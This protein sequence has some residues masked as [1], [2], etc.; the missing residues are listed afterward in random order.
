MKIIAF[1]LITLSVFSVANA[2]KVPAQYQK[3]RRTEKVINP[4][5]TFNYFEG[6]GVN[7]GY[8]GAGFNDSGWKAVSIPHTWS[9]YGTTGE[10]NPF[11]LNV[12]ESENPYWWTGWGWY[13]K[14]FSISRD[15]AD[16]KA[17]IEFEGVQK[18][19]RVWLNG[20]Y[21]GEHKGGYGSF[22][23][24]ISQFVKFGEDNLLAV[25]VYNRQK[26]EYKI[27]PMEPGNFNVYG[28]I[29]RD[30]KLVLTDK[31]YIPMQG[32]GTH[33]GGTF[34]TTPHISEKEAVARV[35]TWVKND[36]PDKKSCTLISSILDAGGAVVQT[37]KTSV[38]I[39]PG[40][41]FKFDQTFKPIKNPR[42]WSNDN[43]YLYTVKTQVTEGKTVFDEYTSPLG[44]R[45]YKWNFGDNSLLLN[46]KK[47][48]LHGGA[49]YQ[50][51][52]WLGDAI[53][54]WIT[55][56]DLTDMAVNLN[57]N[58]IRTANYPND[59]IVYDLADKLGLVVL[60]EVPDI[61]D[62]DFSPEAQELQVR[63][64]I[65]R[66]R[67]HPGIIFWA[68]GEET[69]HPADAKY[70][71]AE[72]TSRILGAWMVKNGSLSSSVRLNEKNL[73]MN[74]LPGSSVRGWYNKDVKNL[75]TN[76][77][78]QSGT[79]ENG[80]K[81]LASDER[82]GK[83]NIANLIYAD[84]GSNLVYLNSPLTGISTD[85]TVDPYRFPKYA[86]YLWQANY[87]TS[88]MVF[89]RPHFWRSQYLGQQKDIVVSSN[90]DKVELKVNGE[91]KGIK[92]PGTGDQ[93]SVTFTGITV[94][95]GT[96]TAIGTKDG[97]TI[98]N[99]IVLAGKPAK[100]LLTC[101]H[102][103]II[104]DRASVA[105]IT[106][107]ITDSWG[108]HVYGAGN[109]IKWNV[110]GPATLAGPSIYESDIKKN[111]EKEGAWYIDMPVSNII[112]S[113][114]VKGLI[115]IS[116]SASELASGSVDLTAEEPV[117]D[118][119]V[120]YEPELKD[121]GRSQVV[122]KKLTTGRLEEIPREIKE[123]SSGINLGNTDKS[124]YKKA[125][126]AYI[127]KDNETVDT[128]TVEF[129]TLIDVLTSLLANS[130]GQ[131]VADDYNFSVTH[132][133]Y[134]RL[135]SRYINSTKLPQ[136]FKDGLRKYYS[137]E[138]ILKGT[139]KN[140]G[141]EMNWLNWIPSGGT[142]VI[143]Q[144]DKLPAT[145]KGVIYTKKNEL[146][147]IIS[148]VYPQFAGFSQEAKER[149]LIFISKA[150][151]YIHV[152]PQNGQAG[153]ETADKGKIFYTAEPGHPILIPLIKFL[154][155]K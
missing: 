108:N 74:Y 7:K 155:E 117:A 35:M 20:K 50:D 44:F 141:D 103:K 121:E 56:R 134:C 83:G 153:A 144:D 38:D 75:E 154:S 113:T 61:K 151:P 104:A 68:L 95:A 43:P 45:W 123:A 26:D 8:E 129:R 22:D 135:I 57:F 49:R 52:P 47:M 32:S 46:G 112:R 24:D 70:A 31:L 27:P 96:L 118:N 25:A 148:V 88:P 94:E 152:Q 37:V 54:K 72:D 120:I 13:R 3:S 85:G 23:F 107:D 150:N 124:G 64:M 62:Q 114:G 14:H 128:T 40:D 67:N 60:E 80:A 136:P 105:I 71:A 51:Y 2:Q 6:T 90:C 110:T 10:I 138:V 91:S 76:S 73:S 116:A 115:H 97:K 11:I 78:R 119:S 147:D 9:T 1:C 137:D 139:E 109:T 28:G 102:K 39:N 98:K 17:F 99:E 143:V 82:F 93:H 86:Y 12:S 21:L 132:F 142:V 130:G 140:A 106:A 125:I 87:A 16:R 65:R 4:Q 5:W 19:C 41:I 89:I 55:E 66:D 122:R 100:I 126:L 42:L 34:V 15:Y 79:E 92:T 33:E 59:K 145:V 133:N 30:V 77:I 84:H 18:F 101:S 29:Y 58:F 69:S 149:A 127:R 53:P 131:I 146:Q 63:E 48:I 111:Q 81:M 36:Y